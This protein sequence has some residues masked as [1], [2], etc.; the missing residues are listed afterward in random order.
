MCVLAEY[1]QTLG[2]GRHVAPGVLRPARH[3]AVRL[4]VEATERV[5]CEAE[6]LGAVGWQRTAVWSCGGCA[7]VKIPQSHEWS[8][9]RALVSCESDAT[10]SL[11]WEAVP[12]Q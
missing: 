10:V 12:W 9:V 11:T 8:A 1:K 6:V 3:V 7:T 5:R 4:R 2:P